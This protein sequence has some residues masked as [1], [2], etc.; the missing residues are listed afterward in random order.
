MALEL[1]HEWIDWERERVRAVGREIRRWVA[2][3]LVGI[4]LAGLFLVALRGH[5]LQMRYQ[6]DANYRLESDLGKQYSV[7]AA[8]YWKMRDPSRLNREAGGFVI[9][10]CV[11]RVRPDG[12]RPASGCAR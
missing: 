8:H 6:L 10:D 11:V 12:S 2:P 4:A 1:G 5:L 7:I 3:L 9:P